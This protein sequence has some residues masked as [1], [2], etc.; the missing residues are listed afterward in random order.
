MLHLLLSV[1]YSKKSER[2]TFLYN[3]FLF[4]FILHVALFLIPCIMAFIQHKPD[5]FTV[6]M[7]QAGATYVLMPLQK[8]VDQDRS[9]PLVSS[10]ENSKKSQV[11]G[12]EEYLEKLKNKNKIQKKGSKNEVTTDKKAKTV[13]P[14]KKNKSRS[15][16]VLADKA[17]T[18]KKLKNKKVSNVKAAKKLPPKKV[19]KNKVKI[20]EAKKVDI[21]DK[22]Q[23]LPIQQELKTE[24]ENPVQLEQAVPDASSEEN[25]SLDEPLLADNP[26][27]IGYEQFDECVIGSKIQQ[28]IVQSWTSPVGLDRN[29]SCEIK[30]VVSQ[31]GAAD[32]T[33]I[34]KSSGILVFDMSARTALQEIEFPKEVHGKTIMIALGN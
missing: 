12:Y 26:I 23:E 29:V 27:F 21:P 13:E 17:Y 34:I 6:S 28:A 25:I 3:L 7:H 20:V 9:K 1:L 32:T 16:V 31:D 33:E 14:I 30:I 10:S 19:V 18:K 11:L 5:R 15:S 2:K 22:K 8:K 24:K 4:V